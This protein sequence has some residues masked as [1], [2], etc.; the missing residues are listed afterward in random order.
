MILLLKEVPA[1]FLPIVASSSTSEIPE[2]A[3]RRFGHGARRLFEK[4]MNQRL[5]RH[6]PAPGKTPEPREQARINSDGDQLLDM[7]RSRSADTPGPPELFVRRF[8]DVGEID[9]SIR[10]RLC[11]PC[12]S[13]G[14]H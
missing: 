5:I 6:L 2:S 9:L 3:L 14:A 10:H 12:G 11:V 7:R 8:G 13:P 1:D 4:L